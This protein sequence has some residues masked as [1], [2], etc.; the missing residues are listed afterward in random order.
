MNI[1]CIKALGE[2]KKLIEEI[3][4]ARKEQEELHMGADV[5]ATYWIFKRE[6][7]PAAAEKAERLNA[8]FAKYPHWKH[9]ER[10]EREVRS[11]LYK[12]LS[13]VNI[14]DKVALVKNIL[15]VLKEAR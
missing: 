5:F 7:I 1:R 13:N 10:Y 3:N 8:V 11:E 15:R 4:A 14:K 2:L 12:V 6:G 9:S